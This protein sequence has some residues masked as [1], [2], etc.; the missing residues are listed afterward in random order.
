MQ[1]DETQKEEDETFPEYSQLNT[2]TNFLLFVCSPRVSLM[3][4]EHLMITS[5]L[6]SKLVCAH[7][8]VPQNRLSIDSYYMVKN[9]I[10]SILKES[11]EIMAF[12]KLLDINIGVDIF[13]NE[14]ET[15]KRDYT[16]IFTRFIKKL[17]ELKLDYNLV[18]FIS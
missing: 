14:S 8:C 6:K 11:P 10:N 7:F 18:I 12:F 3:L 2:P 4:G 17:R 15:L 16:E 9:V 5:T 13:Y 1:T